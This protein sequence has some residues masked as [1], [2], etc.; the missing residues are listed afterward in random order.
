MRESRIHISQAKLDAIV[1]KVAGADI[2]Y[3]PD[4]DDGWQYGV[5]VRWL[6]ELREHWIDAYDW[7]KAEAAFNALPGFVADIDGIPIHFFHLQGQG[8]R[9]PLILTHGWPGSVL[10][11]LEA[12][13]L[14]T[15]KGYDLVIPSL[16]GYGF[17]GRPAKPLGPAHVASM[18]RTLMTDVLGYR[19]FGAQ[20]GDW[21]AMVTTSLGRDH[22]DVVSAIHVNMLHH[23]PTGTPSP[24]VAE[25]LARIDALM[26][27]DGAYAAIHASR[28][29]TIG[30][31]LSD[32]P[33]GFAGWVC[34]KCRA[35]SDCNGDIETRFSKDTLITNVMTYLVGDNVQSA[36][37]MYYGMAKQKPSIKRIE[38]PTGFAEF[39]K[40]FLPPPPRSAVDEDANLV[41]WNKM[42]AGGHF[43][44]WEVPQIFAEEVASFFARWR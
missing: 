19:R 8:D 29:Q 43:A 6:D 38:V 37:W 17:S 32:T 26:R 15:A 5:N 42:A 7:R 34:E 25:Y 16:P 27:R 35:W 4:D 3:S 36:I 9:Y 12:A 20:G 22:A 41:R 40:E 11:F 21:G 39:P 23:T 44:A 28:P 2:G 30:F 13:P 14:L 31:A 18:W 10:E 24:D 1:R 33:L